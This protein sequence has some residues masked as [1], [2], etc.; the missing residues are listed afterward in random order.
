MEV[1]Q[2]KILL[3]VPSHN[4]QLGFPEFATALKEIIG[5]SQPRFAVGIFGTW[6]SGK[7]TLMQRVEDLLRQEP[8]RMI[9]ARFSAWRYEKE[10]HLIVP[11]LDT[12]RESLTEWA[13]HQADQSSAKETALKT[14]RTVGKVATA[15]IRGISLKAA[16]PGLVEMSYDANKSLTK[17][18]EPDELDLRTPRSFYHASFRALT[19]AFEEFSREDKDRR[20]VVFIDDLDRCLPEGALQVLESMKLFFDLEG[21]VFVVGLDQDVV[22]SAVDARFR[23]DYPPIIA[24][25][26]SAG[27]PARAFGRGSD[28]IKKI[29]Q[30]PFTLPPVAI[31]DLDAFLGSFISDSD[32]P[33]P[34]ATELR[35]RVRPHL[36]YILENAE[37]G[38]NP[39]EI[40]R[41]INAYT[42]QRKV[43]PHLDPDVVLVVQTIFF[44]PA[45]DGVKVALYALG[46]ELVQALDMWFKNDRSVLINLH[47][48]EQQMALPDRFLD[49]VSPGVPGNALL[50]LLQPGAF[51][52]RDYINSGEA[53]SSTTD[54]RLLEL[55]SGITRLLPTVRALRGVTGEAFVLAY[56]SFRNDVES[57]AS[58]IPMV[59]GQANMGL[60][61]RDMEELRSALE[62]KPLVDG[63]EAGSPTTQPGTPDELDNWIRD[64]EVII[65][66]LARHVRDVSNQ[67]RLWTSS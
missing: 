4:P 61:G 49:Y 10:E 56:D 36:H 21:F 23:K 57:I 65:N 43:K 30:L 40:K 63:G 22:A 27:G 7:T 58:R 17:S 6:G 52:L 64:T 48:G 8:D 9:V 51:P 33:G 39:R 55:S 54:P 62:R 32:L 66:R 2:Y 46:M 14:A 24:A 60:I 16:L 1:A 50:R 42:F 44:Q 25:D 41:Y 19:D 11:L 18:S 45:W 5:A 29:F 3:D 34:Q 31:G 26:G 13:D 35:Q 59:V 53:T 67:G 12:L 47:L 15:I 28:Y 20:I 37:S 38:V